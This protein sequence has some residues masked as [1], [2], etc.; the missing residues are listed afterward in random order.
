MN[1][2]TNYYFILPET[3]VQQNQGTQSGVNVFNAV[4]DRQGRWVCSVNSV[5]EFPD[6]FVGN[7]FPVVSLSESDFP[8][9][10]ENGNPV[11]P[12]VDQDGQVS[13]AEKLSFWDRFKI[14]WNS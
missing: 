8:V 2:C 14:W 13:E 10:D 5:T 4:P 7:A 12:D 6:L 9:Y 1:Y 3:F 11:T